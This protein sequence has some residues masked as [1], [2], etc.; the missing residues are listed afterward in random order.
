[1]VQAREQFENAVAIFHE[2]QNRLGEGMALGNLGIVNAETGRTDLARQNLEE[3][4]RLL[5]AKASI[6]PRQRA[7]RGRCSR[8]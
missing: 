6:R 4:L 5:P 3:A 8:P 7:G 1:M 2:T